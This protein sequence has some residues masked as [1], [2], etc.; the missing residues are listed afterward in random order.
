[1]LFIKGVRTSGVAWWA[2]IFWIIFKNPNIFF[3]LESPISGR[4]DFFGKPDVLSVRVDPYSKP[5]VQVKHEI[6]ISQQTLSAHVK[7]HLL[8]Q[9]ADQ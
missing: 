4:Q 7:S 6:A 8:D 9:R 3:W 1:M 2:T 5:E